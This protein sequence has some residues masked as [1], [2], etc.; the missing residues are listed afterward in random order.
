MTVLGTIGTYVR[1][2]TWQCETVVDKDDIGLGTIPVIR[3]NR[4]RLVS[5]FLVAKRLILTT[6][7]YKVILSNN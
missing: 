1:L 4:L 7:P 6:T 5:G 2:I 3:E